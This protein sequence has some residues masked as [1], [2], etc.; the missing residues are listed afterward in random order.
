MIKWGG[1]G[2]TFSHMVFGCLVSGS[3]KVGGGGP[4]QRLYGITYPKVFKAWMHPQHEDIIIIIK[5]GGAAPTFSHTKLWCLVSGFP[6]VGDWGPPQ[7]SC[8]SDC[9]KVG[10]FLIPSLPWAGLRLFNSPLPHP[11]VAAPPPHFCNLFFAT[12]WAKGPGVAPTSGPMP[13]PWVPKVGTSC[14]LHTLLI[15]H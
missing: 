3:P 8:G 6:K 15:P 12:S 13:P 5:W 10:T 11:R 14:M 4:P 1:A 2:P 7:G 9:V